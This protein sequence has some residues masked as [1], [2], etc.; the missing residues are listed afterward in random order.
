MKK[1]SLMTLTV[2]GKTV[3]IVNKKGGK[4]DILTKDPLYLG[5]VPEGVTN[6]G[7]QTRGTR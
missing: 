7:L 3:L 4:K 5:G 2:D 6:E 1:K